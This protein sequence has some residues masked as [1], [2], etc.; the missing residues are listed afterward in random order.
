MGKIGPYNGEFPAARWLKKVKFDY[1][2]LGVTIYSE[3]EKN[4]SLNN[5]GFNKHIVCLLPS[6]HV[7]INP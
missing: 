1:K 2:R 3:G 4:P 5:Q 6:S 7:F